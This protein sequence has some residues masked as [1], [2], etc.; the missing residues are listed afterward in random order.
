[1]GIVRMM[2][3]GFI[4]L[5]SNPNTMATRMAV[6]VLLILTPLKTKDAINTATEVI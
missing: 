4:K 1:M 3:M 6:E 5:F 2:S